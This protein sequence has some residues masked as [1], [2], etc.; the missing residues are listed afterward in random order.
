[1]GKY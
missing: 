1:M